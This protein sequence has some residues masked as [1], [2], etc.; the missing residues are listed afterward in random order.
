VQS[1]RDEADLTFAEFIFGTCDK[2]FAVGGS[3][4]MKGDIVKN[5]IEIN[6]I[7]KGE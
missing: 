7:I 5:C 4:M 3:W 1:G 6:N 2:I